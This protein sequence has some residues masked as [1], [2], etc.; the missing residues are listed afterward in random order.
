[1][2]RREWIKRA[3]ALAGASLLPS[4]VPAQ[5][6]RWAERL[7]QQQ[8][9]LRGSDFGPE[10]IWGTATA[11]YQIEGAW[12]AAGK[13]PSIWDTFTHRRGNIADGSTGD[14]ACDFYHRY[15][16]DLQ[17]LARL[18]HKNFRFSTAWSRILPQGTGPVNEAG[19]DFY[20]RLVDT[21]LE[22]GITP[23]VT[24]YHWDLPQALEDRGGWANRQILSW[25]EAYI[26]HTTARLGDRVKHWMVFNE[27]AAFVGL[28]YL[29]GVHAPG[30][31]APYK[32]LEATHYVNLCQGLGGKTVRETVPGAVLGS[33]YSCSAVHPRNP[34]KNGDRNAAQRLD[35]L[36]NR[37]YLEP[38]LGL[39]YPD[40]E[41][42]FKALRRIENYRRPEDDELMRINFD[43]YGLQNYFRV[44]ARKAAW[45]PVV[46]ANEVPPEDRGENV[47]LTAMGWEVYPEGIGEMLHYFAEYRD[48]RRIIVTEN[49]AAFHD[50]L[51][52]GRVHDPER[53]AF[54][55]AYLKE[56]L[57]AKRA[58]VP[59]EG[60]FLW[61]TMDN[62]EWA[63]GYEPR[64]GMIYVDFGTQERIVKTS[65]KWFSGLVR[66]GS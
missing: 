30:R 57:K 37:L 39:G 2:N 64:F 46:W 54:L 13:G 9:E 34:D 21:C 6:V 62:F 65:G 19:L 66:A 29:A 51:E 10:F 1:M 41:D 23:W 18:G 26:R 20:D 50:R 56:V 33:T 22:N 31:K 14:V 63:E 15:P 3:A 60:Y 43:F 35:A 5:G 49:G 32:F 12:Q 42:G 52:N 44:V 17:L 45:P 36:L 11:A 16:Q 61:S 40:G 8:E 25:F 55:A 7:L 59:V 38:P 27:P 48:I 24:L 47:Q 4:L 53:K 58:G 28:G